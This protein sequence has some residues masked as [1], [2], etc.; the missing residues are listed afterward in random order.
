MDS[1]AF[2]AMPA[3]PNFIVKGTINFVLFS[4]EYF[5]QMT[6]HNGSSKGNRNSSPLLR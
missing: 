4:S 3:R 2:F 5:F 1:R 6:R